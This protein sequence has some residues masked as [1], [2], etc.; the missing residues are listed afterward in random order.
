MFLN[1]LA[2]VL[3]RNFQAQ[4]PS[5]VSVASALLEV[6]NWTCKVFDD[7]TVL[8]AEPNKKQKKILEAIDHTV[9]KF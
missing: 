6:R 7:N 1:F 5:D 9:G 4:L 2:I 8:P 3:Y